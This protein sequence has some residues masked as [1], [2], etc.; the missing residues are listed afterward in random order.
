MQKVGVIIAFLLVALLVSVG[1]TAAQPTNFNAHLSGREEGPPVA[2][3]A[4]GEAGFQLNGSGTALSF[5]LIVANIDNVFAAHVHCAPKGS[6]G[7]VGVTLFSGAPGGGRFNGILAQ[8]TITAPNAG[9]G[10]GWTDLA[11]VVAD[12]QSGDAYVNVH[13]L[14]GVPSGELRGQVFGFGPEG[15]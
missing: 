4:T 1:T 8:G 14:P 12:M 3:R 9:N 2:T 6:N 15:A 7:P 10:C 11:A 13:T 5:K